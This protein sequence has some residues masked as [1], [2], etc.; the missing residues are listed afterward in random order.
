M[1]EEDFGGA[2]V[3]VCKNGCK[4]IWFDWHELSKLDE[5][6]EGV[7][8]ALEEALNSPRISTERQGKIKCPKCGLAMQ[9]HRYKKSQNVS[10][11]ECYSC[12][13]IFL[14]SGELGAIRETFMSDED[15]DAYINELLSDIPD[16]EKAKMDIQRTRARTE[17]LR[18]CTRLVLRRRRHGRL[19]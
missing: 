12:G 10:V 8:N 5:E 15:A 7:G 4:G 9:Q 16:Y 13:G 19:F 6:S 1:V 14:D 3:D 18:K 11:D 2:A 17:A